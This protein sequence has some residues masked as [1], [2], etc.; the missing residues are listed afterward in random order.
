MEEG[1]S[2][3]PSR[4]KEHSEKACAREREKHNKSA[5]AKKRPGK[6]GKNNKKQAKNKNKNKAA[7]KYNIGQG[8]GIGPSKARQGKCIHVWMR[9]SESRDG[10]H[11]QGNHIT[12]MH[13]HGHAHAHGQSQ[14]EVLA[15]TRTKE[16]LLQRV[17]LL[18]SSRL[19]TMLRALSLLLDGTRS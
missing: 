1:R 3:I 5:K 8:E 19:L 10:L 9:E 4:L 12:Q 7:S 6:Q 17:V 11:R 18:P 15:R 14:Q 13:A 2:G 16:T